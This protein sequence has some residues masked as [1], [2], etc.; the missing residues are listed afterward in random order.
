M[1]KVLVAILSCCILVCFCSCE[2]ERKTE[3]QEVEEEKSSLTVSTDEIIKILEKEIASD[4]SS[5]P[6][7][8]RLSEEIGAAQLP[9]D[10]VEIEVPLEQAVETEPLTD[11]TEQK[12]E[13][14]DQSAVS[15]DKEQD[16]QLHPLEVFNRSY[17]KI[18]KTYVDKDG[19][20][21]YRTLKRKRRDLISASQELGDLSA[22]TL[23]S[24]KS[25]NEEKAFLINA[26]NIL[27]MKLIVD[28]Y[29]IKKRIWLTPHYPFDS[30]KH[31]PGG[32]K[33]TFF[34][35]ASFW[36]SISEIEQDMLNKFKDPRLCFALSY[37]SASSPMLRNE[38]YTGAN[39]DA[40]L[41]DRIEKFFQKPD[42]FLIDRQKKIV[43]LSS[44]FKL[45]EKV[46]LNSEYAQIKRYRDKKDDVR[47]YLNFLSYYV[48]DSDVR[49]LQGEE[50]RISY[51]VFDWSLNG[52]SK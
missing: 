1:N 22:N 38:I 7:E 15:E 10:P 30:I 32:R 49:Y 51:M 27:T 31:I 48:S 23:V 13:A 18:L 52:K 9:A 46:F 19:N 21:D 35:V 44:V 26:H 42:N 24:F 12:E 29:P 40:Q 8:L 50:Y 39:L 2:P 28:N 45:Y 6:L 47:A 43:H 20:V 4:Q 41:E 14:A 11:G 16:K 25:E 33:K 3:V 34:K 36:Y 37:A 17:D 5:E